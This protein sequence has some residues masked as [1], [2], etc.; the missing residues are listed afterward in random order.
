MTR[1]SNG[2]SCFQKDVSPVTD[3]ANSSRSRVSLQIDVTHL[4]LPTL[5]N[6]HKTT[7][8][9]CTCET[10]SRRTTKSRIKYSQDM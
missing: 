5:A 3:D 6:M 8:D 2:A 1:K 7:L 10:D 4:H 9:T